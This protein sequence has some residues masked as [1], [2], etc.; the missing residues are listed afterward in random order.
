M[1]KSS[2]SLSLFFV[3]ELGK[4]KLK[5][6]I[7]HEV[8]LQKGAFM[9]GSMSARQMVQAMLVEHLVR[10][11]FTCLTGRKVQMLTLRAAGLALR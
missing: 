9:A 2:L 7:Y 3:R 5:G 4:K 10:S 1:R 11:Q 8:L 6:A